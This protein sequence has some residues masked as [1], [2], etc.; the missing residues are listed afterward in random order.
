MLL[1]GGAGMVG[2]F[3]TPYLREKH[4]LRVLDIAQPRH[5]GIDFVKGSV[6]D[7]QAI[8][9]AVAGVDAFIWLVMK[10]PQGGMVTDQDLKVIRENYEVNCLG[11][12]TFLWLAHL[13]LIHI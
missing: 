6:T 2:S 3:I 5:E 13:S 1:V 4:E 11:L 12:H 7:P 8:E 10:S 9:K